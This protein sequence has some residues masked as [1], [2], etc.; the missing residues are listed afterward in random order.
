MTISIDLSNQHIVVTGAARGIGAAIAH[1]LATADADLTLVG[2]NKKTLQVMAMKLPG[3]GRKF[4]QSLDV[5]DIH[6]VEQVFSEATKV[7]GP[8]HVLVNNAGQAQSSAI[9]QITPDL[10]SQMLAVNLTG[11]FNCIH[12]ALASLRT[13][14]SESC[15]SR[16]INI[17]STSGLQGYTHVSAYASAKH[18]VVGLT[19]SLA[20][21]LAK[22]HITVNAVCPGYTETAIAEQAIENIIR[23]TNKTAEQATNLLTRRNPQQRLIRPEEVASCVLWLCQAESR[24]ING[25]AIAIDGGESAG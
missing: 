6:Q 10:W 17:A 7:I 16:I 24:S 5:S 13:T 2:R 4:V 8:I 1:L 18:G 25:Q 11:T 12:A 19:R 23:S 21:E 9:D 3:N 15:P 22:S 20:L 14:A